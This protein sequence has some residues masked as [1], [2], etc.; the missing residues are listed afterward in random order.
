M[1]STHAL[2]VERLRYQE[3]YR[4]PIPHQSRLC[5]FCRSAVEDEVHALLQCEL[6]PE[7]VAI[8]NSNFCQDIVA[9]VGSMP[10]CGR[11]GQTSLEQ[12]VD[13]LHDRHLTSF[14]VMIVVLSLYA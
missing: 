10:G 4:A 3:R 1:M 7:L 12:L 11:L 9:L 2:A 6:Q 13:I 14:R 8:C 5:R